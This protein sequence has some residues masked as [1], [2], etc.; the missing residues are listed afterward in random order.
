MATAANLNASHDV[1][2]VIRALGLEACSNHPQEQTTFATNR[3]LRGDFVD[4]PL[5][6]AL[7]LGRARNTASECREIRPVA[8]GCA[9]L[10]VNLTSGLP[11]GQKARRW[12]QLVKSE[13]YA[14][15]GREDDIG[16]S[17]IITDC[18]PEDVHEVSIRQLTRWFETGNTQGGQERRRTVIISDQPATVDLLETLIGPFARLRN[19]PGVVGILCVRDLCN[20]VKP[21]H[22]PVAETFTDVMSDMGYSDQAIIQVK[23][24]AEHTL[25]ATIRLALIQAHKTLPAPQQ[26]PVGILASVT[27]GTSR[28]PGA[29]ARRLA[30]PGFRETYQNAATRLLQSQ[31][32]AGRGSTTGTAAVLPRANASSWRTDDTPV[33]T[34]ESFQRSA[35]IPS[36]LRSRPPPPRLLVPEFR[37]TPKDGVPTTRPTEFGSTL[38]LTPDRR[39]IRIYASGPRPSPDFITQL[40]KL[41]TWKT[42]TIVPWL[43]DT[44]RVLEYEHLPGMIEEITEWGVS[45]MK[46]KHNEDHKSIGGFIASRV[47]VPE[48][49]IVT[50]RETVE[51]RTFGSDWYDNL[52]I[53]NDALGVW[54]PL[55]SNHPIVIETGRHRRLCQDD[56]GAGRNSARRA[57]D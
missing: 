13:V 12:L 26:V 53:W 30:Q 4:P 23:A 47:P 35:Y 42:R 54:E 2:L 37:L 31:A 15:A 8:L 33:A 20:A 14:I 40:G 44:A 48:H 1:G 25:A 29:L 57:D 50:I 43:I 41:Y 49:V 27:G 52:V 45:R 21:A 3:A 55:P 5:L 18:E 6:L 28:A 32:A 10:D 16:A 46:I 51:E 36:H 7:S 11:A 17:S 9:T 56:G 22:H 39:K 34:V 38:Y 24:R 19:M